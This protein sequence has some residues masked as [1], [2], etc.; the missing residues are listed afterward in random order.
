MSTLALLWMSLVAHLAPM[1]S[2]TPARTHVPRPTIS[3]LEYVRT[4]GATETVKIWRNVPADIIVRGSLLD[5]STGIEIRKANGSAAPGIL[6]VTSQRQGGANTS[7]H[8]AISTGPTDALGD[9]QILIHYLVE[10][11]G[12]DK[13]NVSL[14]DPATIT[15]L[16][17]DEPPTLAPNVYRLGQ[18]YSLHAV[19][20]ELSN[21]MFD[22]GPLASKGVR[23]LSVVS[24]S[25]TD[26]RFLVRFDSAQAVSIGVPHFYE[27]TFGPR[28]ATQECT[29]TAC[30]RVLAGLSANIG[31]QPVV[32]AVSPSVATAGTEITITGS[33]LV[34]PGYSP[35]V[36]FVRKYP[37]VATVATVNIVATASGNDLRF[38]MPHEV[39]SDSISLQYASRPTSIPAILSDPPMPAI[40]VVGDAPVIQH[41]DSLAGNATPQTKPFPAL[42]A[43]TVVILG[44]NLVNSILPGSPLAAASP[45]KTI[46]SGTPN[47]GAILPVAVGG[48]PVVRWGT[49]SLTVQSAVYDQAQVFGTQRGIDVLTVTVPALADTLT[50]DLT[51]TTSG[52]T[53]TVAGVKFVPAPRILRLERL[54]SPGNFQTVSDGVLLRGKTYRVIGSG[55]GVLDAVGAPLILAQ[56]AVNGVAM[57]TTNTGFSP[58]TMTFTVPASATS[59]AFTATTPL[60]VA[61]AGSFTVSDPVTGVSILGMQVSPNTVVSGNALTATVAFNGTITAGVNAG[62]MV[63][64][65]TDETG[66]VLPTAPIPITTNPMIVTILARP[67]TATKNLTLSVRNDAASATSTSA[68]SSVNVRPPVP[69]AITLAN[70][71]VAGGQSLTATVQLD[72]SMPASSNFALTVSSN[73]PTSATVPATVVVNGN[74]ATFT[75]QTAVVPVSRQVTIA[76]ASPATVGNPAVTRTATLTVN[77]PVVSAL[78]LN[79]TSA[80]LPRTVTATITTSAALFTPTSLPITCSDP[81]V[82]CP[83]SVTVTGSTGTF[84]INTSAV[85]STRTVTVSVTLNGVTTSSTLTIEP[86][87]FVSATISPTSVRGGTPSSITV[88]LNAPVPAGQD[89]VLSVSSS[90]PTVANITAGNRIAAG[91]SSAFLNIGTIPSQSTAKTVTLTVTFSRFISPAETNVQSISQTL[92][93]TP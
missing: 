65:A 55:L 10:T 29:L 14:H 82:T 38:T 17:I 72:G 9:Y 2:A 58:T 46:G 83:A 8:V 71:S 78:T 42:R 79:A 39:R 68:Q 64:T 85:A 56:L 70:T 57:I 37:N 26:A 43:G 24:R 33:R 34:A 12:P 35:S 5:L 47:L 66:V 59:G 52:G 54:V 32:A 41:I 20:S 91:N 67:V 36:R 69:T 93:V 4:Y 22:A 73:D 51:I 15:Q 61:N 19:G 90:D 6:V 44:R 84:T 28:K 50:G 27:E 30:V 87:R 23:L 25:A 45:I 40:S 21:L 60:G 1:I 31:I 11:N 89:L 81:V 92:T 48:H 7:I 63:F 16:T 74:T 77:P 86:L 62:N 53:A 3:G 80:V 75:V 76:V 49:Q 13:F 18:T 88:T